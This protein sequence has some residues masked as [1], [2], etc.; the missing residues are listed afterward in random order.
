M[1]VSQFN[2]QPGFDFFRLT[3]AKDEVDICPNTLRKYNRSGLRFYQVRG[4]RC[5]Y[6]SKSELAQFIRQG[7]EVAA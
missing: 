5:V 2:N 3:K 1:N 7:S 6:V 4:D